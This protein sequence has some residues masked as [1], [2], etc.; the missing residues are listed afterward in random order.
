M[1]QQRILPL[2]TALLAGFAALPAQAD[3]EVTPYGLSLILI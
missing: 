3:L 2:S 1:K